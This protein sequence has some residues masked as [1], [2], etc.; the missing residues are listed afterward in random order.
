MNTQKQN[1]THLS[2]IHRVFRIKRTGVYAAARPFPMFESISCKAEILSAE[3][4][5]PA[6]AR[7]FLLTGESDR[8]VI[9]YRYDEL[10]EFHFNP[11]GNNYLI[12]VYPNE[13]VAVFGHEDFQRIN[14]ENLFRD[15][16]YA[17]DL[18]SLKKVMTVEQLR[19]ILNQF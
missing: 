2:D 12:A 1:L 9:E 5:D 19:Q 11:V 14:I 3:E 18:S 7:Y 16:R 17:F 6:A 4:V 13:T 10:H 8:V 15:K